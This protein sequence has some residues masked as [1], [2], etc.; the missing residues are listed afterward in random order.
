M[1][2]TVSRTVLACA[3][4]CL[5]CSLSG[6]GLLPGGDPV[7]SEKRPVTPVAVRDKQV[8]FKESMVWYD[9]PFGATRGIMFPEGVYKLEAEDS[10]YYYF[11]APKAIEYR[12]FSNGKAVDGRFIPGG[13]CLGKAFLKMIPAAAYMTMDDKNKVMTWKLGG[14]FI[15][16]E[17]SKWTKNY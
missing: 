3:A 5:L 14:D 10:E 2:S 6:C 7:M 11:A 15:R 8:V 16:M 17:G 1:G 12:V 4:A 13:L 9:R